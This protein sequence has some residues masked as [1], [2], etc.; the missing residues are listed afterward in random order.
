MSGIVIV[1]LGTGNLRSVSQ[2]VAHVGGGVRISA[3]PPVIAAAS[4]LILP[5]QGALGA[6]IDRL[7]ANPEL[8]QAVLGRLRHGPVLGICLGLQA[9]YAHSEENGGLPGLGLLEGAVKHFAAAHRRGQANH[10]GGHGGGIDRLKIPHMGWNRVR[11]T[12]EHPLWHGI[13]DRSR[14]YFVHSYFVHGTAPGE[15]AGECEYGAT[16]TA[17]AARGNLFATQFHPE[18]SQQAGLRLLY[19]FVNWN[20]A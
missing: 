6:W 16:F 13:A 19:N 20:G 9:L 12:R 7:N 15:V 5:G 14:F 1:D 4:H 2:A 11:H 10:N 18:K 8:R 17:A 3:E